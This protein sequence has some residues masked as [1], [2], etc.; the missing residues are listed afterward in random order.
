MVKY[1]IDL[2]GQTKTNIQIDNLWRKINQNLKI[3]APSSDEKLNQKK[4]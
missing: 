1:K 2:N 4:T 3:D